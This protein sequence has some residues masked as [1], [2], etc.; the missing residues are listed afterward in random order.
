MGFGILRL[1]QHYGATASLKNFNLDD[2]NMPLTEIQ[3]YI[4]AK[5]EA[6]FDIN[7][8]IYEEL[9]ASIFRNIGYQAKV[10]AYT[11]D[12]GID[13]VMSNPDG[14]EV[15]VQVKRYK[16]SIKVEQIRS[17]LGAMVLNDFTK[18]IFV[19]TSN[20]QSGAYDAINNASSKGLEIELIDAKRFLEALELS[21]KESFEH[22]RGYIDCIHDDD[23]IKLGHPINAGMY[24]N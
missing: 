16:N 14:K 21:Q 23:F 11:N 2:V 6:R 10:T 18:G 8:R 24:S 3:N 20:Y 17:F 13:I 19:T 5:Y 12:G 22:C 15:C 4:M 7:P 1:I 9:V